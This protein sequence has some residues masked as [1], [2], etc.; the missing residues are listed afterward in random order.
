MAQQVDPMAVMV[1]YLAQGAL[2]AA[3]EGRVA[4]R[5]HYGDEWPVGSPAAVVTLE[6]QWREIPGAGRCRAEVRL[7]AATDAEV[8][9]LA[10]TLRQMERRERFE[11]ATDAGRALVYF[12]L[13]DV[14]LFPDFDEVLKMPLGVYP[15]AMMY[16][17]EVL[18]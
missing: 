8:A 15:V 2:G 5:H 16:A 12:F 6:R 14:G 13:L 11:V 4:T 18:P 1:A 10:L 3:V 17:E 7:Y 9:Q